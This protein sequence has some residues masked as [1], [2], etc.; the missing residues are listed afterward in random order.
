[1]TVDE[2]RFSV[3]PRSHFLE[4]VDLQG[5]ESKTAFEFDTEK[6]SY[7]SNYRLSHVELEKSVT[8]KKLN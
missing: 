4:S 8:H 6:K 5:S 1:M 7:N 3:P 2:I